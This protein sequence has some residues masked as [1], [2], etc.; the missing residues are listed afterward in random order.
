MIVKSEYYFRKMKGVSGCEA[1]NIRHL[2]K[3]NAGL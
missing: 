1:E 2:K 3:I